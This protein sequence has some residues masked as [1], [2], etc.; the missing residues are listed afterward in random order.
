MINE[1]TEDKKNDY[2]VEAR[3]LFCLELFLIGKIVFR[4][5]LT[6]SLVIE[7]LFGWAMLFD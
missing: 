4:N 3:E 7:L 1:R 6:I 5:E 2:F